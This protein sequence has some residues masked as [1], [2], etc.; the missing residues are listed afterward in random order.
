MSEQSKDGWQD[1]ASAPKDGTPFIV[2]YLPYLG[3]YTCMR[4]VLWVS[5][6]E[7]VEMQDMGAW[8]IV[9]GIDDDWENGLPTS[10]EPSWSIA[11]DDMNDTASWLWQPLPTPPAKGD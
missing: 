3:G 1:I 2:K 9:H 5:D 11:S 7:R 6:G 10:G 4:R 8:L